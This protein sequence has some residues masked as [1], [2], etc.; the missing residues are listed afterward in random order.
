VGV[1]VGLTKM[2][3][4]AFPGHRIAEVRGHI[5]GNST[6]YHCVSS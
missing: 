2:P 1:S 4:A 6:P 5:P 3:L